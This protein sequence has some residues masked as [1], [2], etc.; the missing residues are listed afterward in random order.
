MKSHFL[1]TAGFFAVTSFVFIN[2][3]S[4]S[5]ESIMEM[6]KVSQSK[7]DIEIFTSEKQLTIT[8]D[9][10][11]ENTFKLKSPFEKI[12]L[13]HFLEGK[14]IVYS[15]SLPDNKIS[16]NTLSSNFVPSYLVYLET[17]IASNKPSYN[18]NNN[19][20]AS[21]QNIYSGQLLSSF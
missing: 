17:L 10:C 18:K 1:W 9:S 13:L 12:A 2:V 4:I 20:I 6:S 14:N 16:L 21:N 3:P 7:P 15:V 19:E 8:F 5:T 11:E